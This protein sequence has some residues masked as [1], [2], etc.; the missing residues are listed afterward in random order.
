MQIMIC[1]DR[2][3][4]VAGLVV[5]AIGGSA[6]YLLGATSDDGLKS[7]G[8]YLLQWNMIQWL[9]QNG[10]RWYDLGGIDPEANRGVYSFKKGIRWR[11]RLSDRPL[12][13][14]TPVPCLLELSR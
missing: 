12:G 5:S 7:K 4:P 11:G 13:G 2:G 9:K 6:I 14:I 10:V 3:A 8:A 1:E